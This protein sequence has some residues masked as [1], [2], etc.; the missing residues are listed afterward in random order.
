M[1]VPFVVMRHIYALASFICAVMSL[2][3]LCFRQAPKWQH[4]LN[5]GIELP[6]HKDR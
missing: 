5:H 3:I 6:A 1:G 4:L 2:Y